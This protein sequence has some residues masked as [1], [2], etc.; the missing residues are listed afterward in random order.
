MN[1]KI[2]ISKKMERCKMNK[3]EVNKKVAPKKR[4]RK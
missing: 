2:M 1:L 3:M 4:R